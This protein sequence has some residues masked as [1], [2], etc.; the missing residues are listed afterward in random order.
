MSPKIIFNRI[1]IV[2]LIWMW[3][4]MIYTFIQFP[5]GMYSTKIIGV[6][7]LLIIATYLVIQQ[8]RAEK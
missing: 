7:I 3:G 5:G 4:L 2:L 8:Y 6:I 1:L